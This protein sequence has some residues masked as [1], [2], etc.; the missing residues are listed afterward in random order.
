ML[1]VYYGTT[2]RGESIV[3]ALSARDPETRSSGQ[4]LDTANRANRLEMPDASAQIIGYGFG[5]GYKDLLFTIIPSKAGVKL[6]V[7]RAVELADPRRL[8][9]GKGKLHRHVSLRSAMDFKKPG[10]K[11]LIESAV[12]AWKQRRRTDE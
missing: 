7:A 3:S 10:L 9:Q 8:L 5:S 12:A 6:G 2:Q 11:L 1:K 4:R